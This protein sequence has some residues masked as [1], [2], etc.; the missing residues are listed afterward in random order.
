M[1][2]HSHAV[3]G[4]AAG[5][6][7]FGTATL[8]IPPLGAGSEVTTIPLGAGVGDLSLTQVV[9]ASLIMGV[10]ALLPDID[11][12]S[13]SV[14]TALPGVT[15]PISRVIAKGGHRTWTHS[16]IGFVIAA[17][18]T[19]DVTFWTVTVNGVDVRPGN[20]IVLGLLLAVAARALGVSRSREGTL[21]SLFLIGFVIGTWALGASS[22]W[23]MP[24]LVAAGMWVHRIGDDITTQ[25]VH[26]LLYPLFKTHLANLPAL[27]GDAGSGRERVLRG[28]L[29]AYCLYCFTYMVVTGR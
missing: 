13:S 21:W 12:P 23:F 28:I 6:A 19:Y 11:S 15:R 29:Y 17:F 22:L 3:S 18:V 7:L 2:G 24:T 4:V 9:A 20:G 26:G 1:M 5:M 14:A 25:S 10:T 8:S 16:L 27:L